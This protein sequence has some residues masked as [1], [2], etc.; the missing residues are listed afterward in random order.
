MAIPLPGAPVP[1]DFNARWGS[2]LPG[3]YFQNLGVNPQLNVTGPTAVQMWQ[4][5]AGQHVDGVMVMDIEAL[6]Q[7]LMA[8]GPVTTS[9]GTQVTPDNVVSLLM[10]DQYVGVSDSGDQTSRHEQLGLIARAAFDS[11][12]SGNSDIKALGTDLARASSGR[13]V[14]VWSA[15]PH[16]ESLWQQ[17]GVAGDLQSQDL[18][19]AVQNFGSNK[20][21]Y[22]LDMSDTLAVRP[23]SGA[24]DLTLTLHLHNRVPEGESSYVAGPALPIDFGPNYPTQNGPY[25]QYYGMASVNLPGSSSGVSVDG[26]SPAQISTSG[27]EGPTN[28]V[29]VRVKL[30]PGQ[31][32]DVT[33]HFRMPGEHGQLRVVPTARVPDVSWNGYQSFAETGAHTVAW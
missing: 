7:V 4:A 12:N 30:Q 15:D 20:L 18:L 19:A 28:L 1:A 17:A 24:T 23:S 8:T 27:P 31:S 6:H 14:M 11:A 33:F 25:G 3:V 22:F 16:D 2:F 5:L 10:H 29:A 13:H 9:D 32:Q 21:D 26:Y